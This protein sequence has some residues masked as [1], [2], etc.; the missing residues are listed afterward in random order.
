MNRYMKFIASGDG[1]LL[2]TATHNGN[3]STMNPTIGPACRSI[4]TPSL[5]AAGT[6]TPSSSFPRIC[7][8][9]TATRRWSAASPSSRR[10]ADRVWHREGPWALFC[11]PNNLASAR[12]NATRCHGQRY[13]ARGVRSGSRRNEWLD[14]IADLPGNVIIPDPNGPSKE[15]KVDSMRR[16][17]PREGKILVRKNDSDGNFSGWSFSSNRQIRDV[18]FYASGKRGHV[19]PAA[20][21]GRPG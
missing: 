17:P 18:A 11:H 2:A 19:A 6:M 21:K 12:G 20:A 3:L 8:P 5:E 7:L 1:S 15:V 13:A 4:G 9:A 16:N 10:Q 14:A